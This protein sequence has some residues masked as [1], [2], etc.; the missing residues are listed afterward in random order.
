MAVPTARALSPAVPTFQLRPYRPAPRATPRARPELAAM[1]V[2]AVLLDPHPVVTD[3]L[4]SILVPPTAEVVAVARSATEARRAVAAERP[5]LV[6]VETAAPG[7]GPGFVAAL[8]DADEGLC[9]VALTSCT[10]AAFSV[11]L[12]EAGVDALVLKR[13][14]LRRVG[15]AIERALGGA[16]YVDDGLPPTALAL[17]LQGPRSHRLTSAEAEVFGLLGDGLSTAQIA[18][19]LDLGPDAVRA[20][21]AALQEKLGLP[22]ASG[23]VRA[24]VRQRAGLDA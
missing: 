21:R 12:L 7:C 5:G 20:H 2:P 3:A 9:V 24:A 19:A 16:F 17:V 18:D 14:S 6:V 8:R 10:D 13:S 22:T 4:R 1:P 11:A 23:L 15:Y